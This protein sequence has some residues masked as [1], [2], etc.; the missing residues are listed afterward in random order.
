MVLGNVYFYIFVCGGGGC[1]C[2]VK[3]EYTCV[4]KEGRIWVYW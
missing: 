3:R 4:R 2:S 1:L